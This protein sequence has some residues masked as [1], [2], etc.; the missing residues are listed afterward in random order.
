MVDIETLGTEPGAAILSI[1]AC[2]FDPDPE[3]DDIGDRVKISVDLE[4]CQ[5]AGLHIDADTLQWWLR[6]SDAAR[7]V[8]SGGIG[9]NDAL[10]EF[11]A[12]LRDVDADEVWANSPKFDAAHLE[13]AADAVDVSLPWAYYELRDVRT[14]RAL[15]GAVDLEHEGTDHDALDDA[16]HQ[17][18]EVAETLRAIDEEVDA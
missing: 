6:Q 12:W 3:T 9:L 15:P 2:A 7:Y 5:A 14:I 8:L 1:G 11:A 17:A 18:R 16:I 10:G 13:H 4:S